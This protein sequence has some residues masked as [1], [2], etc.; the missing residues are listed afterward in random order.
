MVAK[1]KSQAGRNMT[2]REAV[3]VMNSLSGQVGSLMR[4]APRFGRNG[5]N[6]DPRRDI[7]AECGYNPNPTLEDYADVYRRNGLAARVVNLLPDECWAVQPEVYETERPRD[8]PFEKGWKALVRNPQLNPNYFLHKVDALSGIGNFGG[9]LIGIDDKKPSDTIATGMREDG[10]Y[11]KPSATSRTRLLFLRALDQTYLRIKT[12]NGNT[13]SPRFGQPQTYDVRI[14]NTDENGI[15]K[16]EDKVFH[17]SRILHVAESRGSSETLADPKLQRVYDPLCDTRK[18]LGG[19]PEML[20]KGGF[21]AIAATVDPRFI[22]GG[23]DI[24]EETISDEMQKFMDGLQKY[25]L[26]VGLQFNSLSS[27]VADPTAHL[28]AQFTV[29]AMAIGIPLRVFMGSESAKLASGQDIKA[30]NK[31]LARRQS[32]YLSPR[33]IRPFVERLIGMGVIPA[34]KEVDYF[35][36]PSFDI[37]WPDVA[38]PDEN[39]RSTI[40]DRRSAAMMK[41][42]MGGCYQ[43]MQPSDFLRFVLG[44]NFEETEHMIKNVKGTA[45]IKFKD[46]KGGP[47]AT[48]KP[49][50]PASSGSKGS[51]P[52]DTRPR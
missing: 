47:A 12:V 19:S 48:S 6:P 1:A 11:S 42:V 16:V 35:G 43:L 52:S 31:R 49:K 21:P 15:T 24:N 17:W 41:Y 27:Q 36:S 4:R 39:E 29:I 30:W 18:I 13:A 23:I 26:G 22:E 5:N 2:V 28:M 33:L 38:M 34:P 9:L 20:W 10:T 46:Q 40:A 14:E 37:W 3:M 44:F 7:D 50:G 25:L 8:T 45:E 51:P 32:D